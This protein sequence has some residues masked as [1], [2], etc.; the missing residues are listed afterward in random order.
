[1]HTGWT[2]REIYVSEGGAWNFDKMQLVEGV[3]RKIQPQGEEEEEEGAF[4]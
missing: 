2:V 3:S 4:K 1:M